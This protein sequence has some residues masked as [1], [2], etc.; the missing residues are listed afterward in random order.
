M[1]QNFQLE[2]LSEE[3]RSMRLRAGRRVGR[4]KVQIQTV[5]IQSKIWVFPFSLPS[6]NLWNERKRRKKEQLRTSDKEVLLCQYL[7]V[8]RKKNTLKKKPNCGHAVPSKNAQ[9]PPF[10]FVWSEKKKKNANEI[11][12][13]WLWNMNEKQISINY[14]LSGGVSSKKIKN[15]SAAHIVLGRKAAYSWEE[16][17]SRASE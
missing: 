4:T 17:V 13:L 5:T 2:L 6:L 15:K 3:K 1:W 7:N 8:G 12:F 9:I 16:K 14:C 11:H 10:L